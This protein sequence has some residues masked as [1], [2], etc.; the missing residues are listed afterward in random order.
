MRDPTQKHVDILAFDGCPHLEV[1]I[2]RVRDAINRLGIPAD[3]R[4]VRIESETQA[5]DLG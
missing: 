1:A 5:K 2:E 3:V 4:V